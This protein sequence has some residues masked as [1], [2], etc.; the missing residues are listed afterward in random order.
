MFPRWNRT[1]FLRMEASCKR[2]CNVVEQTPS[3]LRVAAYLVCPIYQ[4]KADNEIYE[5]NKSS[6][7]V[8]K[9]VEEGYTFLISLFFLKGQNLKVQKH[10]ATF[11]DVL[12]PRHPKA[13]KTYELPSEEMLSD[14]VKGRKKQLAKKML[15]L[16]R[17][18]F[19]YH[20][21]RLDKA[22]KVTVISPTGAIP[23]TFRSW[24]AKKQNKGSIVPVRM[25]I[26]YKTYSRASWRPIWCKTETA[27]KRRGRGSEIMVDTKQLVHIT[28]NLIQQYTPPTPR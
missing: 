5:W 23:S 21:D 7:R 1:T 12:P 13:P 11:L 24:F 27:V 6:L 26:V 9:S 2:Q 15:S 25:N 3:R 19:R 20:S 14:E 8:N 18:D 28:L 22:W 17:E 16:C 4:S 10:Q